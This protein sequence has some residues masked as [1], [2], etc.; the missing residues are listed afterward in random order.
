M[1]QL[2]SNSLRYTREGNRITLSAE[3]V[4]KNIQI[5]IHDYGIGMSAEERNKAFAP[6]YSKDPL[7][8]SNLRL[9]IGLSLVKLIVSAHNG[10]ILVSGQE[11]EE[12]IISITLP[13]KQTNDTVQT[14]SSFDPTLYLTNRFSDVFVQLAEFIELKSL[15]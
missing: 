1:M 2:I 9:G 8:Y 13:T 4:G 11:N 6:F 12:T 10:T 14:L 3:E 5:I 7:N 15:F